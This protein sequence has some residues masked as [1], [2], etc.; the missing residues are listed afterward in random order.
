MKGRRE[1]QTV[2]EM[3]I[4]YV[5]IRYISVTVR[6]Q[7]KAFYRRQHKISYHENKEVLEN[8][9]IEKRLS[10]FFFNSSSSLYNT[11]EDKLSYQEL[12][13]KGLGSLSEVEKYIIYEKFVNQRSDIDIGKDFSISSQMVSK[14]KRSILDKLKTF[15]TI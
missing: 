8:I 1:R 2:T 15:F 10:E 5:F 13:Y 12:L 11:V 14:R 4:T 3:D 7:A 6:R 9:E